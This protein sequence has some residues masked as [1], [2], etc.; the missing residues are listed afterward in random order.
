MTSS[1]PIFVPESAF[2]QGCVFDPITL[3][4]E[5]CIDAYWLAGISA[6]RM[7]ER[8]AGLLFLEWYTGR[9]SGSGHR[10]YL[11]ENGTDSDWMLS[12]AKIGAEMFGWQHGVELIEAVKKWSSQNPY[13]YSDAESNIH[14]EVL[15]GFDRRLFGNELGRSEAK[16]QFAMLP[17]DIADRLLTEFD[18]NR[19]GSNSEYYIRS[20]V[21]LWTNEIVKIVPDEEMSQAVEAA[22]EGFYPGLAETTRA[23]KKAAFEAGKVNRSLKTAGKSHRPWW[24]FW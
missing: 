6:D 10:F 4:V 3:A 7:G 1:L 14:F 22:M 9:V 12:Y 2:Q 16:E 8:L 5:N 23:A 21:F 17:D 24:K 20:F 11:G 13:S 19:Y 18:E 15:E